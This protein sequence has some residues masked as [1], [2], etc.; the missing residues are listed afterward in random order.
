MPSIEKRTLIFLHIF[1]TGGVTL[2]KILSRQFP[3]DSVFVITHA[4]PP[5]IRE[6]LLEFKQLSHKDT[7]QIRYLAGHM[8][9]G[10]HKYLV[11]P[12][13]YT[14]LLRNPVDRVISEYYAFQRNAD[15]YLYKEITS[16]NIRLEDYVREGMFLAWNGQVRLLRETSK[17]WL[18]IFG[19]VS[20]SRKNLQVAKENLRQHFIVGLTDRFD[21]SLILLKRTFGWDGDIHY[22]KQNVGLRVPGRDEVS[23]KAVS[24]IE[25]YNQLD[26]ELYEF[27]KRM[28]EEKISQQDDTFEEE[29]QTFRLYNREGIYRKVYARLKNS[30]LYALSPRPRAAV[31]RVIKKI[32]SRS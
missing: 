27:G 8:P 21:E 16:R 26:M 25:K 18:E 19:P 22:A 32:T 23:S 12:C 6:A 9:F 17:D 1:K 4:A 11:Q 30:K 14:T 15:S 13:I 31:S 24:L 20:L 3:P 10:F 7:K 5:V 29:L 2:N 28:F